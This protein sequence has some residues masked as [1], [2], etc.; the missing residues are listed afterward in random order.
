MASRDEPDRGRR[1]LTPQEKRLRT[2]Q[3]II[4]S[5]R[6]TPGRLFLCCVREGLEA[7]LFDAPVMVRSRSPLDELRGF[8]QRAI[9]VLREPSAGALAELLRLPTR[10]VAMVLQD[11]ET[12][13][14]ASADAAGRWCVPDGVTAGAVSDEAVEHRRR[15][16]LCYWPTAGVLLPVLPSLLRQRDLVRLGAHRLEGE[17]QDTYELIRSWTGAEAARRGKPDWLTLLPAPRA[18]PTPVGTASPLSAESVLVTRCQLDV[19]ALSWAECVGGIWE[20]RSRLWARPAMPGKEKDTG[21]FAPGEPFEGLAVLEQ[22]LECDVP[23]ARDTLARL[24]LIF[25]PTREDWRG[26]LVGGSGV[27]RQFSGAEGALFVQVAE[28]ERE[29][30]WLFLQTKLGG[31]LTFLCRALPSLEPTD[32]GLIQPGEP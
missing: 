25:D 31:H 16:L 28:G 20:L 9:T 1:A 5:A 6:A 14:G 26:L 32:A 18:T 23:E 13:G 15:R 19:V 17:V 24:A 2:L 21:R 11:L 29:P 8:V 30:D 22:L 12:T 3:G 10:V 4:R 27:Q 7:T